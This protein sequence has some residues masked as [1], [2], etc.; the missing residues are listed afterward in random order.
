MRTPLPLLRRRLARDPVQLLAASLLAASMLS[1]CLGG[2]N[3]A[4]GTPTTLPS[5]SLGVL[6]PADAARA[7]EGLCELAAP[8]SGDL[9]AARATF[10]D[11]AHQTLH[12]I[13]AAVEST[14]PAIAALLQQA[15]QRVE[16]DLEATELPSGFEDDVVTLRAATRRAIDAV[17]ISV[18]LCAA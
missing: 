4:V 2:D 14:D 16:G 8:G 17:G 7:M 6:T 1:A 12:V 11:E 10:F 9:E 13:A 5:G 15:K 3:G 18:P